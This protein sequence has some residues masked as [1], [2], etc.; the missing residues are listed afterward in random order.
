MVAQEKLRAKEVAATKNYLKKIWGVDINLKEMSHKE[1]KKLGGELGMNVDNVKSFH[2][3]YDNPQRRLKSYTRICKYC[4]TYYDV[5]VKNKAR[6][7]GSGVCPTCKKKNNEERWENRKNKNKIKWERLILEALKKNGRMS[8]SEIA[9]AL[10][11]SIYPIRKNLK[12]LAK[13]GYIKLERMASARIVI[14]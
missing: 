4:K 5:E 10:G 8:V 2:S 9:S 12:L 13:E 14:S 6:P 11:C 3:G 7:K 1:I